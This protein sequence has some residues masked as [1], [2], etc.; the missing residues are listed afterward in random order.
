MI[1][2]QTMKDKPKKA[3]GVLLDEQ[4][5]IECPYCGRTLL[6]A[7]YYRMDKLLNYQ[8]AIPAKICRKC[9]KVVF[10]KVSSKVREK[11]EEKIHALSVPS[12]E[13]SIA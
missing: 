4:V 6:T 5:V 12:E 1:V 2:E 8:G 13:G 10:L 9:A 7:K 11:L 3:L